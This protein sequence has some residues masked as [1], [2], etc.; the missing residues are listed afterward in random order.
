MSTLFDYQNESE[1]WAAY[2]RSVRDGLPNAK[3]YDFDRFARELLTYLQNTKVRE[4]KVFLQQSGKEYPVMM[5]TLDKYIGTD[6]SEFMTPEFLQKTWD[7]A[8]FYR[9]LRNVTLLRV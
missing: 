7:L 4:P 2:V 9:R 6:V 1:Q 3:T 8:Q 5:A